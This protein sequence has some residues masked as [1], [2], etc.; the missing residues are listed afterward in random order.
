MVSIRAQSAAAVSRQNSSQGENS[1]SRE[2]QS[3]SSQNS[4]NFSSITSLIRQSIRSIFE[5]TEMSIISVLVKAE[6][7]ASLNE[8]A[9]WPE[10][11]RKLKNYLS[12]IGLWKILT[13]DSSESSQTDS[14]KHLAWSE[15]QEQLEGLLGLIL[16]TSARSLIERTTG[17]NATQQYKILEN[18]YNKISI[19]IFSQV[20][21]RVFKGSWYTDTRTVRLTPA[22][23]K[24]TPAPV[25]LTPASQIRKKVAR[26]STILHAHCTRNALEVLQHKSFVGLLSWSS[27]FDPYK[28]DSN[29]AIFDVGYQVWNESF[30]K[31]F[32][33]F[34]VLMFFASGH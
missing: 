3:I 12:M 21:R 23:V 4:P 1:D 29:R 26:S 33:K 20:Y 13:E 25:R 6:E 7:I 18:E 10:W 32:Q 30:L 16:G 22:P 24:L 14:E 31:L 9:D 19:S 17:K 11:N 15:K 28:N 2:I 8:S 34:K 27:A 5:D